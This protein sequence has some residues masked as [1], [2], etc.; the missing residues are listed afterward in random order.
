MAEVEA[1]TPEKVRRIVHSEKMFFKPL[2]ILTKLVNFI[3]DGRFEC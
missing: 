3:A 1:I 2:K